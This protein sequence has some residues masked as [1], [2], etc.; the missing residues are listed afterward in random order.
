[1]NKKQQFKIAVNDQ[2]NVPSCQLPWQEVSKCENHK[3]YCESF[4]VTQE[5]AGNEETKVLRQ[6]NTIKNTGAD[7]LKVN[8]FSSVYLEDV[9]TDILDK[10]VVIH[11]CLFTW[12]GEGRWQARTLD[13]FGVYPIAEHELERISR[14]IGSVGSWSTAQYYPILLVENR[15]DAK[16]WFFEHLGGT[17]WEIELGIRGGHADCSLTVEVNALDENQSGTYV[18][19]APDQEF[20]TAAA[21]YGVVDGDADEAI[22]ELLRYKR[23]TAIAPDEIPVCFNDYMNCLWANPSDKK[24]I[25]LIDAAAE[26]GVELFCI[27]DGWFI[28]GDSG[29]GFGDWIENDAKFGSY[30]FWGI[31]A[32]IQKKGMKPGIWFELETCTAD[33]ALYHMAPDAVLRR[34][35]RIVGGT[36]AVVN[37]KCREVTDYLYERILYFYKKGIRYIKNDYNHSLGIG[38]DN[39][40]AHSKGIGIMENAKAFYAFVDRVK[41]DMPEL[42]IEN[43]GSGAMRCDHGTLEHFHLQSISDHEC[44]LNNPSILWGMQKCIVPE[45]CG[46]WAYPYP[47]LIN[48]ME[49]FAESFDE[50]YM[51]TMADGNQTIF[52]MAATLFGVPYISGHIERCDSYNRELIARAIKV[53]KADRAFV[54]EALPIYVYPQQR[55]YRKGYSVLALQNSQKIRLGIFKNHGESRIEIDLSKWCDDKAVLKEIYPVKEAGATALYRNGVLTFESEVPIIARVYEITVI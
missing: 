3:F 35:G 39:N 12:S 40:N 11:Y 16:T 54:K 15:T 41:A 44:Y 22:R 2:R 13:E 32:Y 1:M 47:L 4:C 10:E 42:I 23:A 25:P 29:I 48:D 6:R 27:D 20:T 8:R 37:F 21:L 55:F 24:L 5:I 53:Y 34:E 36:K 19:L 51:K 14:T 33:S 30:G 9:V 45:K 50:S 18:E 17:S 28:N 31:I 49:R 7:M 43:C 46:I 52:N 26:V 38:C